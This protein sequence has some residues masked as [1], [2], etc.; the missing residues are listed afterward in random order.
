MGSK[1]GTFREALK[2]LK[3]EGIVEIHQR[4]ET[5]VRKAREGIFD[6]TFMCKSILRQETILT[7]LE[8]KKV[9]ETKLTRFAAQRGTDEEFVGL[10]EI[11]TQMEENVRDDDSLKFAVRDFQFHA[12]N[13]VLLLMLEKIQ[14]LI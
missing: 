1:P 5:F 12:K 10:E 9:I 14:R 4:R 8:A 2:K 3:I 11:L 6:N 13:E 7:L